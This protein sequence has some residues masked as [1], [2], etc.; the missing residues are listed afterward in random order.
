MKNIV[1]YIFIALISLELWSCQGADLWDQM[2]GEV[3][4]FIDLYYPNSEIAE[5]SDTKNAYIVRLKNGPGFGFD[6]LCSWTWVNGYGMPIKE[7][8]I[9]DEVPEPLYTYLETFEQTGQVFIL[10]RNSK[11]YEVSLLNDSLVYNISS[12]EVKVIR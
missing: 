7:I 5:Y 6:T 9:Y 1:K 8:L 11:I 2:P 10:R 12:E 4:H 3:K